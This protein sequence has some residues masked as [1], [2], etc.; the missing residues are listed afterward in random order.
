MIETKE[1]LVTTD[2]GVELPK[3]DCTWSDIQGVWISNDDVFWSHDGEPMT[4]EYRDDYFRICEDTGDWHHQNDTWWDEVAEVT[5]SNNE[6]PTESF[7]GTTAHDDSFSESH[8]YHYVDRGQ[9]R[10]QYVYDDQV[11]Y[12]ED[13]DEYVYENRV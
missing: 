3:E 8:E 4:E 12:C 7:C 11:T 5:Y 10:G 2:Q 6:E 13:I 1:K 9:A